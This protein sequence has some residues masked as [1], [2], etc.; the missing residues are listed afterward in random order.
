MVR[1]PRLREQGVQPSWWLQLTVCLKGMA[2]HD[3]ADSQARGQGVQP[4]RCSQLNVRL[5]GMAAPDGAGS[6]VRR[7]WR[8][9]FPT[10]AAHGVRPW[11]IASGD[12]IPHADVRS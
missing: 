2:A 12:A 10:V 11:V 6:Q 1:A 5:W 3:G 8:P 7:M 9:A 4:N